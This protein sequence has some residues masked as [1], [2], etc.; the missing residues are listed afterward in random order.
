MTTLTPPGAAAY[1]RGSAMDRSRLVYSS[2]FGRACPGCGR[3]VDECVCPT[4]AAREPGDGIVRVRRESKGRGGKT[5]TTVTGVPLDD[6]ALDALAGE[7]KRRCGCG[8]SAKDGIIVIQGEHV[9]PIIAELQK[10]GYT[11]KKSGG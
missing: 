1:G 6:P 7:L 5:V 3:P 4:R 10:R 8:G 2:E 9:E 11:A